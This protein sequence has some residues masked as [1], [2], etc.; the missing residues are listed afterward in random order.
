LKELVNKELVPVAGKTVRIGIGSQRLEAITNDAGDATVVLTVLQRPR[1]GTPPAPYQLTAAFDEDD[2][3]LASSRSQNFTITKASSSLTLA[4]AAVTVT[5]GGQWTAAATLTLAGGEPTETQTLFFVATAGDGRT[6]VTTTLTGANGVGSI[7]GWDL[8]V[9]SY[10]LR[11]YFAKVVPLG[12]TASYDATSPFYVG[13]EA[14]GTVTVNQAPGRIVFTSTRNGNVDIYA[15]ATNG[16][17]VT[18]LTTNAAIDADPTI[19]PDGKKIVFTS[20]RDGNAEIY[21]MN[22]DGTGQTRLTNNGAADTFA[23]WSPDGTKIAFTSDRNGNNAEIFV[24]NANGTGPTRLTNTRAPNGDPWYSP[25]GTK[26]AFTST[27]DGNAE[28]YVM[29]ANGT[30]QT[31]LTNNGATDTLGSW[32]S[33]GK[34]AFASNRNGNYEIYVM[35]ANGTGQTRLTTNAA[36]DVTPDW[37]SDGRIVFSSDR[38]GNLEIYVMN[39]DGTGQ[40]RLSNNPAA[41]TLPDSWRQ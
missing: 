16:A 15:M 3:N 13:A 14:Q 33:T 30:G 18:R 4:P 8:P 39:G 23:T 26:I 6:F 28:I 20:T 32:S 24:M 11:V 21:V 12:G 35:N 29:N 25:D 19:S 22:A 1:P 5:F 40:T 9:G 31:R 10:T 34:I 27:R 36:T 38:D 41:D 37:S 7:G 17:L 2:T